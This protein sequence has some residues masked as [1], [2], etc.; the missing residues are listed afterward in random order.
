M[1]SHLKRYAIPYSIFLFGVII[2]ISI[3]FVFGFNLDVTEKIF[4]I[5]GACSLLIAIVTYFYQKK[6]DE[7]LAAIDQIVF[8]REKVILEWD[9][10]SLFIRGGFPNYSFSRID[11]KPDNLSIESL[12][13]DYSMNFDSQLSIIFDAS[14]IDVDTNSNGMKDILSKQILLLNM[15]EEFSIRVK[16]FKT[17]EHSAIKPVVSPIFVQLVEQNAVALMFMR[18]I[19]S[20]NPIY[21]NTLELY[22][23]WKEEPSKSNY[24]N[25]LEKHGFISDSQKQEILT[26]QRRNMNSLKKTHK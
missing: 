6:Q 1:K 11:I 10:V 7:T 5:I 18:D 22:F 15:L 26:K 23:L 25:N 8:F 4:S 19:I 16:H 9:K 13:H 24:I 3:Y 17:T 21:S 12:R 14:Q 20:N 2:S